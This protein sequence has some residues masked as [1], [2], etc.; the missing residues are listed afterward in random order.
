MTKTFRIGGVHPAPNKT[1]SR[2]IELLPLP[3][4]AYVPLL[5][6]KGA[7]AQAVVS[8]GEHVD[9]G[10]IIAKNASFVSAG[11]HSPITGTVKAIEAVVMPDGRPSTAIVIESTEQEH[12]ADSTSRSEYWQAISNKT[13]TCASAGAEDIR[14]SII[15]AG[16]VGL[17]GATFPSH[18]KLTI[19][20]G[21]RPEVL[22]IN[23]CEC[24]PYL[25]ADDVLMTNYPSQVIAGAE[26]MLKAG[27]IAR[28]VIAIED[29]KPEA[30][31]AI[32]ANL[33]SNTNV[34][35]QVVKTKYPQGGEKQL[36]E[37]VTGRRI[38]S[39]ELPLAVGATV[40]NVA[41]AFAIWQ[42][43]ACGQPLIERLITVSG[44]IP[45]TERRNYIAAIGT[46]LSAIPATLPARSRVVI[47]GPMMGRSA[48]TLEAPIVK[49][50]SGM[51]VLEDKAKRPAMACVR[52]GACIE[53][54]PMGLEPYL[55]S[56][57]G[58]LRMW[59]EARAAGVADCIEC[60]S[61]SWSCPSSRPILEYISIAK[62][63][64][65]KLS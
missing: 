54:C 40:N 65:K 60:G 5:Q 39:G 45:E 13:E 8:R 62:K 11:I 6:H 52:C 29:N 50:M 57:Y 42:A 7:P 34:S 32:R 26:L 38:P 10:Q 23:G 46:R 49:G 30:I 61:C 58:R 22:I 24:E 2:E 56:T 17:G 25:M 18:V 20:E 28:A 12:L 43:V 59:D 19:K 37:A 3:I 15:E 27:G 14:K 33:G 16:I 51:V 44:N 63:R 36:I 64:I 35:L 21:E 1:A 4:I 47:G 41:T 9:R 48:V 53:A 31:A 55:I